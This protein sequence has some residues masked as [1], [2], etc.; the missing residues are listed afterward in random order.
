[1]VLDIIKEDLLEIRRKYADPRRTEITFAEDDIDM[2]ELIERED[3]VVTL[4]HFGYIKRLSLEKLPRAEAWRQGH[5]RSVHAGRGFC[6]E[7]LC[8]FH[9]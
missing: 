4:T 2:D 5:H 3:M 6:G 1:M 7:H 8:H 9:A